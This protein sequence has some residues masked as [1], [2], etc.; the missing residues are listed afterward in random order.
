[1]NCPTC[2]VQIETKDNFCRHCGVPV[3]DLRIPTVLP[4]RRIAQYHMPSVPTIVRRG[5]TALVIGK[6]VE[7]AA[8]QVAG[9]VAKTAVDKAR[10]RALSPYEQSPGKT[11][12]E[13][14]RRGIFGVTTVWQHTHWFIQDNGAEAKR[15]RG[16]GPFR[17]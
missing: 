16:W 11:S 6:A 5:V 14:G 2:S 3:H 8:R 15:P 17:R 10:S 12:A 1:M 7:W 13:D 9:K 4:E